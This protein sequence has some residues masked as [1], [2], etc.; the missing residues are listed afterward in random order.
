MTSAGHAR[1]R[2]EV[3]SFDLDAVHTWQS[4]SSQ[5]LEVPTWRSGGEVPNRVVEVK[6]GGVRAG[7][8]FR[9]ARV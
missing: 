1:P 8:I 2:D 5:E 7:G 4:K 6:G 9:E 3:L